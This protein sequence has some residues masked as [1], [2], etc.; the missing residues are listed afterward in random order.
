[1][2]PPLKPLQA[3]KGCEHALHAKLSSHPLR[4]WLPFLH[5]FANLAAWL[6]GFC[7]QH[8]ACVRSQMVCRRAG[9]KLAPIV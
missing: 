3:V 1:M 4:H 6:P 2:H 7:S 8:N 9:M 5:S